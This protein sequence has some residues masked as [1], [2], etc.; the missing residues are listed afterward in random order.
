[1]PA[2]IR[3]QRVVLGGAACVAMIAFAAPASAD[4]IDGDWCF[5]A[6][7]I[8]IQGGR[9]KTPAGNEVAGDYTRHS[10]SYVAPASEPGAGAKISM[11]LMNEELMTLTRGTPAAVPETWKRC[12]PTS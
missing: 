3:Y 5:A 2:D 10:F 8:N 7:T 4:A 12:R 6:L 11:Q 9:L 1:M